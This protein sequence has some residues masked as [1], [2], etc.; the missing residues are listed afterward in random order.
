M[1]EAHLQS[2]YDSMIVNGQEEPVEIAE[3]E[4]KTVAIKGHRRL[5][6]FSL[7][8]DRQV[9][10]MTPDFPVLIKRV[11]NASLLDLVVRS[12]NDNINRQTITEFGK[13]K[14]ALTLRKLGER[15]ERVRVTVAVSETTL[16]RYYRLGD[17]EWMWQHVLDG[18]LRLTDAHN[19]LEAA[20]NQNRAKELEKNLRGRSTGSGLRLQLSRLGDWRTGTNPCPPPSVGSGTTSSLT[21]WRL[22]LRPSSGGSP[23]ARAQSGSTRPPSSKPRGSTP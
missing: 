18:N 6:V 2:L 11:E 1:S 23:S 14:G 17:N 12:L 7:M 20:L 13:V 9:E 22:G 21:R 8:L 16:T 15:E 3:L 10:G 4:G 19:L 5:A